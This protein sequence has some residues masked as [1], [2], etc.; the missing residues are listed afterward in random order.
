MRCHATFDFPRSYRPYLCWREWL[1]D[2]VEDPLHLAVGDARDDGAPR[3][4]VGQRQVLGEGLRERLV[5]L[6][7]LLQTLHVDLVFD[8]ERQTYS[9]ARSNLQLD[10]VQK[11]V[12]LR[13]F[14]PEV[15]NAQCVKPN[16]SKDPWLHDSGQVHATKGMPR[17]RSL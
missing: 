6:K 13:Y 14:R 12:D 17:S 8:G 3:Q 5:E 4:V 15:D 16:E 7:H 10:H 9:H 11:R 2:L 1:V